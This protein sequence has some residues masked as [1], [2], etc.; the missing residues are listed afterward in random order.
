MKYYEHSWNASITENLTGIAL[1][2]FRV[3]F[4]S[5]ALPVSECATESAGGDEKCVPIDY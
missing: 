4:F 1:G 5:Q 3:H 2:A